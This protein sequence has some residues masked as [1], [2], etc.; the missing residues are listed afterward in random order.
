MI[1]AYMPKAPSFRGFSSSS[2]IQSRTKRANRSRNTKPEVALRRALHSLGLRF[3]LKTDHLPG[4]PDLIF[5]SA[6]TAVFCDGDFW[7]GRDW[8][9][10]RRQLHGRANPDYWLAKIEYNRNRDVKVNEELA[11]LGWSVL[12]LWESEIIFNPLEAAKRIRSF[13]ESDKDL[14]IS[15]VEST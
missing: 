15:R 10:L 8:E 6:K 12:R 11:S 4:R 7:H 5:P 13:V 14:S 2:D 1:G 9:K 3:R